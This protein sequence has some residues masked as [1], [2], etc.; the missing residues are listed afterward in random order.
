MVAKGLHFP[1]VTLVGV[2]DADTG[3][4][5]PDFR[6]HER[7]FQLLAQVSGRSGRE[8]PGRVILQTYDPDHRVL[9][10]VREHDVAGFLEDE[11]QQRREPG[12]P[13]WRRLAGV[14]ATASDEADLDRILGWVADRLRGAFAGGGVQV[15]G[16]AR[17]VL[18]RIN[19]RYR[20]QI[21]LKGNLGGPG[22]AAVHELLSRARD[23]APGGRRV[24]LALDVDPQHLL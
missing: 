17:A 18:P 16:P 15:L 2:I 4:H 8:G 9:R 11:L 20:G 19:R 12:Y 23:E 13:P 3:L 1:R 24:D 14:L 22:K 7:S 6:A 5:F 21:L 10:R